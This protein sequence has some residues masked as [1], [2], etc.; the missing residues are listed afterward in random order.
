MTRSALPIIVGTDGSPGARVAVDWAG[1]EAALRGAE[2][3]V[4]AVTEPDWVA[5]SPGVSAVPTPAAG[6]RPTYLD[7]A[8]E[9]LAR[10]WPEVAV[11]ARHV[12]GH[13]SSSIIAASEQA[14]L[15][16][17]GARGRTLVAELLLGSVS[18][19][20]TAHAHCPTVVVHETGDR[21]RSPVAVGVDG[22]KASHAALAAA[23]DEALM[24][25]VR[26]LVVHAWQDLNPTGYGI[27]LAPPDLARD[28]QEAGEQLTARMVEEIAPDFPGLE[29]DMRVVQAHAT[30]ALVQA[31]QGAQLVVVGSHG[32]GHFP[33]MRQGS[34]TTSVV[35]NAPCPVLVVPPVSG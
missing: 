30:S 10:R 29:I 14:S 20:V 6:G 24:R 16:V 5:L 35:H 11:T 19:H 28:L 18:R 13:A 17:V 3:E 9:V 31:A 8:V 26:L 25:G 21:S 12:A 22:S 15:V 32:R 7:E 2:L 4:L 1:Q 34:V 27:Y 23:A 33:G